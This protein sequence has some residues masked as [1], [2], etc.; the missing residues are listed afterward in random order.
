MP[1]QKP[2][3]MVIG[4]GGTIG[5]IGPHRLDYTEYA[6]LGEKFKIQQS[7]DRIPE[8]HD[9]AS[10]ESED[11]IS[12]GSPA[13]GPKE[14]LIL[15]KRINELLNQ[16]DISGVVVTHGTATLEETAFFLN[17]TV[18]SEKPVVITGA[19]RPPT[20][21][22]TD[23]DLNLIDSIRVA[24]SVDS[25]G[26]GVLTVLNNEIHSARDVYK[27]NTLRVD[28][29]RANELGFLGYADSDG[30]VIF[31]RTPT[32]KHTLSTDF[33]VRNLSILPRVDIVYAFAGSD[34]LLLEA[35]RRNK[36]DGLVITGFGSGTL[37][38]GMLATGADMAKE[39]LPV[40]LAS[41][42]T[43][44]RT[45]ITPRITKLG[46]LVADNLHPQKAR[47]LLMLGLT[48]SKIHDYLQ[49]MFTA[50]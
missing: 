15:T 29:F 9:V 19:M 39:G 21:F 13:I 24:A 2:R 16:A 10:I 20:A 8:I 37:P 41:R 32:R 44:G 27:A 23:A 7:L 17:L 3:I 34:S 25:M 46:F 1:N 4:T 6:E 42:S 30:E 5:G 33:D 48:K 43:A 14:W 22:S 47:I 26:K 35:V 28:T 36:S 49:Q 11:L 12:V 40:V 38:P 18:K 31:Y 45:V 50:Y